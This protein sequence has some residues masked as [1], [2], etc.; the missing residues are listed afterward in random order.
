MRTKFM[1]LSYGFVT[2]QLEITSLKGNTKIAKMG[3]LG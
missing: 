1:W 3:A 2:S